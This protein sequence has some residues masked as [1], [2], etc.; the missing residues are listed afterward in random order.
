MIDVARQGPRLL[1]GIRQIAEYRRHSR[2]AQS[3]QIEAYILHRQ[4]AR[5][6]LFLDAA[7]SRQ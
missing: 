4:H 3:Q 2:R 5:L 7:A 6:D 1:R